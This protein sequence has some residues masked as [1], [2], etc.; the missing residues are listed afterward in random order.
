M[1]IEPPAAMPAPSLL[2]KPLT[3]RRRNDRAVPQRLRGVA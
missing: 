1:G 3:R 2:L